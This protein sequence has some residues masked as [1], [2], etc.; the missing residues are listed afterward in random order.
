MKATHIFAFVLGAAAGAVGTW[1]GV[2][3]YYEKRTQEE[4]DSVK[5]S[6]RNLSQQNKK[7]KEEL[8]EAEALN[9]AHAEM[10]KKNVIDKPTGDSN[11]MAYAKK[12]AEERYDGE[13]ED[14]ESSEVIQ[15]EIDE[16]RDWVDPYVISP[17]QFGEFDDY[18]RVTFTY[19]ADGVVTDEDLGCIIDPEQFIG[20]GLEHF[21]EYDDDAVHV[22]NERLKVDYE[23]LKDLRKYE[24][25]LR[26]KPYLAH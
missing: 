20:D 23:I 17:D 8:N 9:E 14:D 6:F 10:F 1:Y 4:I 22:R 5:E 3:T 2:R 13:E 18:A 26:D 15:P 21:G 16:N 11:V 19:F 25:V 12:I 24:D 7:L